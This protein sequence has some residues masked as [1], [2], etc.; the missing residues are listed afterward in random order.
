MVALGNES[1]NNSMAFPFYRVEANA[2]MVALGNR[3]VADGTVK[4][5][6]RG[7]KCAD[8]RASFNSYNFVEANEQVVALWEREGSSRSFNS[9]ASSLETLPRLSPERMMSER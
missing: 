7:G 6:C 9:R 3:L 1:I 5:Y 8:G 2:R 4:M